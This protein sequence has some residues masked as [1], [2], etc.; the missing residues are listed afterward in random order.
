MQTTSQ[1]LDKLANSYAYGGTNI[2]D[3]LRQGDAVSDTVSPGIPTGMV[4]PSYIFVPAVETLS[5]FNLGGSIGSGTVCQFLLATAGSQL[6]ATKITQ[7]ENSETV[8]QLNSP[9]SLAWDSTPNISGTFY[10]SG[11]DRYL[12][13]M[14][15]A[16]TVTSVGS[17]NFYHGIYYVTNV[18]F[19]PS[20]TLSSGVLINLSTSTVMELPYTDYGFAGNLIS[21]VGSIQGQPAQPYYLAADGADSTFY[22]KNGFIY[23]PASWKNNVTQFTGKPRP[24][25][26]LALPGS[27]TLIQ[28][29]VVNQLVNGFENT[30]GQLAEYA[31]TPNLSN[32]WD[33]STGLYPADT[34]PQFQPTEESIFGRANN[35]TG[36][37]GWV[38]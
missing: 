5:T 10:V 28:N 37:K 32:S 33:P 1:I 16:R 18:T 34:Q 38:G 2:P 4:H 15:F 6:P 19:V 11:Y 31:G 14:S 22:Y 29:F 23:Y 30:K 26:N 12:R 13:K 25:I 20:A 7:I 3:G 17:G 9:L 27:D 8:L 21:V 35:I 24:L 36:W